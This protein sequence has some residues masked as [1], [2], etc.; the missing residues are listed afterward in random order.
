[1]FVDSAFVT[2]CGYMLLI[3][4][5]VVEFNFVNQPSGAITRPEPIRPL[6]N[7]GL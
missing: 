6:K 1:M 2:I 5:G 3:F 7:A 4:L